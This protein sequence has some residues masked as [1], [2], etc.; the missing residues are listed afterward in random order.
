MNNTDIFWI[1]QNDN[2]SYIREIKMRLYTT[3]QNFSTIVKQSEGISDYATEGTTSS[4]KSLA[5]DINCIP[6]RFAIMLLRVVI[7]GVL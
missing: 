4:M 3:F 5:T 1:L 6:L 7:E 2:G